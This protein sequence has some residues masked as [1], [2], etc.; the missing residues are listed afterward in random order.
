L[1]SVCGKLKKS[2]LI[3]GP[4][5]ADLIQKIRNFLIDTLGRWIR[6]AHSIQ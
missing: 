5:S 3:G 6:L 4:E 2:R 1:R